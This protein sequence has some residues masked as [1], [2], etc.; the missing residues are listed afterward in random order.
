MS[1][2]VL[3]SGNAGKLREFAAMLADAGIELVPQ[4]DFAVTPPPETAVTF[5]ENALIKARH[6]AR[7][8]GLAAIADDSG[9][10][11][12]ALDGAPGVHSARYAGAHGDDQENNARL[13]GELDGVSPERRTARYRAVLVYL[14]EADDPAPIVAEGTWEGRIATAPRGDGGFGYDPLF[15]MPDGR[16]AA[17]LPAEEKNL[18]SHRGKALSELRRRLDAYRDRADHD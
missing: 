1:R 12:D 18:L 8:T 2:V 3:A 7:E 17:Q 5:I 14:R 16:T 6:A 11:V 10:E 4:S 9:L 15:E 13:L